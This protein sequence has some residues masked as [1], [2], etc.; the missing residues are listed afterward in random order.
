MRFNESHSEWSDW[1]ERH[2]R[3]SGSRLGR[4]VAAVERCGNQPRYNHH[5][6]TRSIRVQREFGTLQT[7][8]AVAAAAC[9][10]LIE[11]VSRKS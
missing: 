11:W 7:L 1:G 2:G 10:E 5:A 3:G 8:I 4:S 6:R 9:P